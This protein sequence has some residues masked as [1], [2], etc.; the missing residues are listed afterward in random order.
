M[1]GKR[2][3]DQVTA[4]ILGV[5]LCVSACFGKVTKG[6]VLLRVEKTRAAVMWEADEGGAG[7]IEFAADANSKGQATAEPI[8]IEYKAKARNKQPEKKKVFV[9]KVWLDGL[10]TGTQYEYGIE[11]DDNKYRFR[12]TPESTE[13]V[14]FVVYGDTRSDI[15]RHKQIFKLLAEKKPDFIVH[16][17]DAVADG[18][19]YEQWSGQYFDVVNGVAESTPSSVTSVHRSV[20]LPRIEVLVNR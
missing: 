16:T 13:E 7:K 9:Y 1:S 4:S 12:T 6:P 18:D 17:G 14:T 11:G 19:K 2:K 3:L 5:L 15:A 20:Y 8:E 10:K